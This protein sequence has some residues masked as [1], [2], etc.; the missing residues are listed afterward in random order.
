MPRS[1]LLIHVSA[2]ALTVITAIVAYVNLINISHLLVIHFDSFRGIDFLG[3]KSDV[4]RIFIWATALTFLNFLLSQ[5][6]YHRSRLRVFSYFFASFNILLWS[7]ILIVVAVI[8]S[9]N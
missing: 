1:L 4:L 5:F 3:A 2:A 9:V 7:L 8:I 6:F